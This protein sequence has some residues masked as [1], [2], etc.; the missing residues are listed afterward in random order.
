M[1]KLR[2]WWA[3]RGDDVMIWTLIVVMYGL[4]VG[5]IVRGVFG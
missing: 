4:V 1:N 2:A 5:S 3:R